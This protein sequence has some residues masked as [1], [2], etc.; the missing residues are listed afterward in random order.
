M[1]VTS[2]PAAAGGITITVEVQTWCDAEVDTCASAY[3]DWSGS[4][5]GLKQEVNVVKVGRQTYFPLAWDGGY[6]GVQKGGNSVSGK[7]GS[8]AVFSLGG[9]GVKIRKLPN[10]KRNKN[11]EAG[12]DGNAGASCRIHLTRGIRAGDTYRYR[13]QRVAGGWLRGSIKLPGKK[14]LWIADLKPG[15]EAPT[16]FTGLYNFIEY[17]GPDLPT[18]VGVPEATIIFRKPA[19][20]SEFVAASRLTGLCASAAYDNLRPGISLSTYGDGN[21]E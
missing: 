5:S 18:G 9:A 11:C 17:F 19:S 13:V 2:L 14:D 8:T 20:G 21:C 3:L 10:G 1:A 6:I 12:F 16:S 4:V 15:P 7:I